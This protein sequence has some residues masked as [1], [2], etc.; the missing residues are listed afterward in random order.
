[1]YLLYFCDFNFDIFNLNAIKFLDCHKILGLIFDF[2]IVNVTKV[3]CNQLKGHLPVSLHVLAVMG[4]YFGAIGML[5]K[6]D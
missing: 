6:F 4:I 5:P 1:M 2:R 3:C